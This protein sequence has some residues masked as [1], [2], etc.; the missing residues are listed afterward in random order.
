MAVILIFV[1]KAEEAIRL[2]QS[3]IRH[4][5]IPPDFYYF[6]LGHALIM[7]K[8]YEEATVEIKKAHQHSPDNWYTHYFLTIAYAL[9]DREEEASIASAEIFRI[10]P[11]FS[12][13]Y[14]AKIFPY[15]NNSDLKLCIDALRIAGLE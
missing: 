6:H 15:K 7:M 13:E 12:L 8:R 4:N 2:L 1:G 14:M 10:I 5:P 11:K 3:A 9:S